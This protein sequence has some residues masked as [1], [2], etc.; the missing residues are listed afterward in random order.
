M[1][2][3]K[4]PAFWFLFSYACFALAGLLDLLL[5]LSELILRWT[6]ARGH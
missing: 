2:A 3:L 4:T 1:K 6:A 5:K